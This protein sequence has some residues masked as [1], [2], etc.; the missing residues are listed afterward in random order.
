MLIT[1]DSVGVFSYKRCFQGPR[2]TLCLLETAC[3]RGNK[4]FVDCEHIRMHNTR[5]GYFLSIHY[6]PMESHTTLFAVL[7]DGCSTGSTGVAGAIQ[8]TQS[9]RSSL[10][11]LQLQYREDKNQMC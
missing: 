9:S 4:G 11:N 8:T 5:G 7:T 3:T 6:F 1:W 2:K 10:S